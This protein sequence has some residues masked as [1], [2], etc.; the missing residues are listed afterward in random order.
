MNDPDRDDDLAR[1]WRAQE[2]RPMDIS[3]STIERDATSFQHKVRLRNALE[4]G[5]GALALVLFGQMALDPSRTLPM[6]VA[7][8]LTVVGVVVVVTNLRLRGRAAAEP[9]RADAPTADVLGWHRAEL[10]RQRD[11]L[12][13]VPVWYI[14]PLVPGLVAHLVATALVAGEHPDGWVTVGARAAIVA[15]V[16]AGVAWL[17][18]RGARQLDAKIAALPGPG[19]DAADR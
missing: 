18:R 14:G 17:N 8:L 1:L 3:L 6:R 12:R 19:G 13:R 7:A 10:V 16:L 4:Y 9:L 2:T 15:A 11:L 5:A